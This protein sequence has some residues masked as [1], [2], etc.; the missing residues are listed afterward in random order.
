MHNSQILL[1]IL[2]IIIIIHSA[3]IHLQYNIHEK[4]VI[5]CYTPLCSFIQVRY[6]VTRV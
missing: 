5:C 6:L 1:S 4:S 2:I 3:H